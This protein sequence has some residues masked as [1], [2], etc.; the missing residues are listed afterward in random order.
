MLERSLP[1]EVEVD[2]DLKD[3]CESPLKA[4]SKFIESTV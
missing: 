3:S 1:Q 2:G 4:E